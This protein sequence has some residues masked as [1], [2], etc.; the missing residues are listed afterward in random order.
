MKKTKFYFHIHHDVLLEPL[1]EPLKNRIKYIKET[2][3]KDE[4]E[5]R[6]KLLKPVKGK[7]PDEVIKAGEAYVKVREAYVKAREAYDKA[8]EAYDKAWEAYGKVREAYGKVCEAYLKTLKKHSKEI[9]ELHKKECGCGWNG[10]TIFS[11]K[12]L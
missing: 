10:K 7:L 1:T 11:N 12:N 3:P 8:R 6:L 9:N 4:I 2:K 5:L